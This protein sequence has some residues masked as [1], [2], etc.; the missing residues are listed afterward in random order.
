LVIYI[1]AALLN[2]GLYHLANRIHFGVD[3]LL[4]KSVVDSKKQ[5]EGKMK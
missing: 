1:G 3:R 4:G 2:L 5:A